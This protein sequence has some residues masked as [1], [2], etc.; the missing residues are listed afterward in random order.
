MTVLYPLMLL[1]AAVVIPATVTAYV[2]LQRRRSAALSASGLGI[3]APSRRAGTRRHLPYLLFLVALALL[4]VDLARPHAKIDVPRAAGTVILVF[5]VSNS[6][7]ADDLAPTRLAAAQSAAVSFVQ[8]QPDSVDIGVV[9]FQQAALTTLV[10]TD[11]HAEALAAINR[12]T[13]NGGTSLGQAILAALT[14][15]VG[16][17]VSL[18]PDTADSGGAGTGSSSDADS[19]PT[20]DL[21]YW[22]SATI[23]LFT[24]GGDTAGPDPE[25]AAALAADAGVHIETIGI[26]TTQGTTI[27]VEGYQV[28]TALDEDLLTSVAETTGGSYHPAKD[29]AALDDIHRSIDLRVTTQEKLVELTA[30][31]AG[32]AL[33]LLT[34]GGLLMIRWYGRII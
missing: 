6:M 18:P 29:T 20:T 19:A 5:D 28:A 22:G 3:I 4:L 12:L 8:A 16:E 32:G 25:A 30:P 11:N 15:I 13:T 31:L 14:T 1:A 33:V 21:G 17:P 34:I 26:G 9:A 7:A 27:E 23:V 10:P 2:L 24:D